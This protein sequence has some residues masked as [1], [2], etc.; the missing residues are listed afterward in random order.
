MGEGKRW[1]FFDVSDVFFLIGP[2]FKTQ[3]G[4]LS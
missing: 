2:Q 1:N 3:K 4:T